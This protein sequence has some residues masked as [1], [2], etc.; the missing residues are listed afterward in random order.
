MLAAVF[1]GRRDI[2]VSEVAVPVPKPDELLLRVATVGVCG[3]DAHEYAT[4]PHMFPVT[5]RHPISGHLGP[6]I[7][8]H[9]L[10]GYVVDRGSEV[11]GFEIGA[12]IGSGAGISC[13]KC[14]WCRRGATNLCARYVTVGLQVGGG[15]AQYAVVPAAICVDVSSL[16]LSPDVAALAQ[17]MSVAVHAMR[18]GRLESGDVAVIVGA[19]GIGAFLTYAASRSGADVVVVDLDEKRL[20]VASSLGAGRTVLSG[21]SLD[22]RTTMSDSVPTVIYEVT[23]T[24]SGLQLAIDAA[25]PGTRVVLVG[26]Q[27]RAAEIDLTRVTLGELDLIGTNAHVFS[28]DFPEAL[29]LLAMRDE[30]WGDIAP[31][32]LPLRDLVDDGLVPVVEGRAE[33]IKTLIDP[34][35]D[36]PRP[37]R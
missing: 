9:E 26:I 4:G 1:H 7:P 23:G 30:G 11:T 18:R 21:P 15:L 14:H 3:T 29:R 27:G 31:V 37:A 35:A 28:V 12:L 36:R 34:W 32:V 25:Q 13:G 6:F 2:R 10:S 5:R 20:R 22:L 8:G 16:G 17:P 33:R 24:V 19:G